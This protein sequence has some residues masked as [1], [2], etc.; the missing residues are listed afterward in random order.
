MARAASIRWQE[1]PAAPVLEHEIWKLQDMNAALANTN[2]TYRQ[3]AGAGDVETIEAIVGARMAR[4]GY[5][6]FS[7]EP[8]AE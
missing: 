3:T 7:C 6:H 2:E 4:F 5:G 8:S 1:L